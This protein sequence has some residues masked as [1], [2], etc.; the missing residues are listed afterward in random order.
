MDD[1]RKLGAA[2]TA[3]ERE[4]ENPLAINAV[5]LL[6]L[7]GCRRG[8]VMSLT[9]PEVDLEARQLRLASTK[10]GYSVR[11]LG[12]PAADLLASLPRHAKSETVIRKRRR[13]QALRRPA[14][15]PGS[16]S[17]ARAKLKGVTLHTL[18]AFVRHHGQHAG[19]LRADHRGDAGPLARH[20]DQPLRARR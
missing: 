11:P 20:H 1:Y 12:Q 19:L 2:L 18:A 3:A 17:L 13:R 15:T 6:A 9:W 4:G 10:E 5:R 14:D 7:T 8:E 16:A